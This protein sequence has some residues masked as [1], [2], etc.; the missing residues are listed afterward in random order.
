MFVLSRVSDI[1]KL[2]PSTFSIP[3][4]TALTSTINAKFSN[5]VVQDVGLCICLFDILH[6]SDG[7]VKAGDGCAYVTVEFRL[8]VFRPF[9][10]EVL[11]GTIANCS[12]EGI[13]VTLGFFDDILIP[14]HLLFENTVL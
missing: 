13:K 6:S 10:G 7:V 1:V 2:A 11:T 8:V 14:K 12:P 3:T 9:I 4:E 5:R